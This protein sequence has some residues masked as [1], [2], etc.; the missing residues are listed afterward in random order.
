MTAPRKVVQV[1]DANPGK[2][3]YLG[4]GEDFLTRFNGYH[5]GPLFPFDLTPFV[6]HGWRLKD[7]NSLSNSH[8]VSPRVKPFL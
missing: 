5:Y 4:I 7:A 3:C 6:M 1:I 8:S 2:A